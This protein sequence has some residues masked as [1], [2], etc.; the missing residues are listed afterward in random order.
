MP[1]IVKVEDAAKRLNRLL[2]QARPALEAALPRT[3]TVDKLLRVV[4]TSIRLNPKL[5]Q[6]TPQSFL[7]CVLQTAALGLAPD[8]ILGL[9]YLVPFEDRK[10][11]RTL[12]QIII[13]YR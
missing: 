3:L 5:L 1:E 2:D 7:S 9:A 8:S 6:C 4:L 13:G 12:C 10:N 11:D